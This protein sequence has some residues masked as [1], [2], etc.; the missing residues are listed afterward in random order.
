MAIILRHKSTIYGLTTELS[1]LVLADSTE[2]TNRIAGDLQV[3][4][5]YIAADLVVSGAYIAA[6]AVVTSAFQLADSN[7]VTARNLAIGVETT[8]RIAADALKLNLTGGTMT[9]D[10]QLG[11]HEIFS[12]SVPSGPSALV[13]KAYADS[14]AAGFDPKESVRVATTANVSLTGLGIV[15]TIQLVDGNRVLV[16][17]QTDAK[18]NGIYVAHTGAWTR[19]TDFDGTPAAEISGG[20]YTYV[21]QG[22]AN[23]GTNYVVIADGTITLGTDNIVWTQSSGTGSFVNVLSE[24]NAIELGAG[25]ESDG[26]YVAP[27]GTTY[28]G[29]ATSLKNAD[30]LLD[31]AIKAV[32]DDLAQEVI[33]RGTAVTNAITTA[34]NFATAADIVVLQAAKDYA[35][36]AATSGGSVAFM[37]ARTVT[38]DKIVLSHAPKGGIA[39]IM[40]FAT[41]RYFD[42]SNGTSYDAPVVLDSGDVTGKT[43]IISV[44]VAGE[45][46]TKSVQV[47]YLYTIGT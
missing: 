26:T 42:S 8:D 21:E 6:D 15:D 46:D 34:Q 28:L 45:W 47:Q 12:S 33:D 44:N 19:S 43:F 13:N 3:H 37:E 41:V 9:G 30:E 22:A 24:I 16:K 11:V 17:N 29:A 7:E 39:G 4:N 20:A 38:A 27:T 23:V 35:D 18:E 36:A 25:L 5:D 32:S 31:T 14:I 2:V 10:I 1:N 40:N